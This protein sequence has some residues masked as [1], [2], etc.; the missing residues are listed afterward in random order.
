MKCASCGRP[1]EIKDE[2]FIA[3]PLPNMEAVFCWECEQSILWDW[4]KLHEQ[5]EGINARD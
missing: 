4:L 2:D 3:L 5:E 1:L